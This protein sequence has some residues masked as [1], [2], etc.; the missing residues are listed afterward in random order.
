MYNSKNNHLAV[1]EKGQYSNN[2][3]GAYENLL[4]VGGISRVLHIP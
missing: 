3:T 4:C 2:N 1:F